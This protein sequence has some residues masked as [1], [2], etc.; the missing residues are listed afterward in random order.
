MAVFINSHM[1]Y[2]IGYKNTHNSCYILAKTLA[3]FCCSHEKNSGSISFVKEI[4]RHHW[5]QAVAWLLI[6]AFN[7]SIVGIVIKM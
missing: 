1:K 2:S 6:A 7:L 5:I 4:S 3:T